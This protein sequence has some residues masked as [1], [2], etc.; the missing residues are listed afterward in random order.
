VW[1]FSGWRGVCRASEEVGGRGGGAAVRSVRAI[2]GSVHTG[3]K[4]GSLQRSA[5]AAEMVS[6]LGWRCDGFH[7]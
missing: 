1:G 6:V 4:R 2:R 7:V 5:A 3:S